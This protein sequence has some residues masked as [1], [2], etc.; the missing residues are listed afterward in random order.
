MLEQA[1]HTDCAYS[2]PVGVQDQVGSSPGQPGLVSDLEVGG[3]ECSRR[4]GT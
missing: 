3:P 1:A 4:A 2:V